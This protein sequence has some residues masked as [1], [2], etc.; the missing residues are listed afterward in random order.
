VCRELQKRSAISRRRD[1][2]VLNFELPLEKDPE[3]YKK[4]KWGE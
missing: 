4:A 2:N 3:A 1:K